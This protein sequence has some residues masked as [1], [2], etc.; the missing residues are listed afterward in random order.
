MKTS[1]LNMASERRQLTATR[2]AETGRA[3]GWTV[4]LI[5]YAFSAETP[6][7]TC[8]RAVSAISR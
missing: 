5:T 1:Q 4:T 6:G 8:A 3:Q 2:F 7:N